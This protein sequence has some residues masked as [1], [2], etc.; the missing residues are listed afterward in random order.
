MTVFERVQYPERNPHRALGGEL[1]LL[2]QNLPEQP[3]LHPLHDHVDLAASVL[4]DHLHHAGVVH[5]LADFLLTMKALEED[6]VA[7]HL[8]MRDLDGNRT[9]RA[10]VRGAK[11]R[12]HAAARRHAFDA[13]MIELIARMEWG[14]RRR[15]SGAKGRWHAVAANYV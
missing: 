5:G 13:V 1:P 12:G 8:R 2:V 6:R 9:A 7:L 3:P 11:D 4:G 14:H 15:R 10:H